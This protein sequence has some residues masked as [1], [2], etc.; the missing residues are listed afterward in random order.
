MAMCEGDTQYLRQ[1]NLF[2]LVSER[3]RTQVAAPVVTSLA[4]VTA[5]ARN[6]ATLLSGVS[7]GDVPLQAKESVSPTRGL[8]V[9]TIE[10]LDGQGGVQLTDRHGG[11]RVKLPIDSLPS[12]I[13]ANIPG[14][15][16]ER[17]KARQV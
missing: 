1:A 13:R 10:S 4:N 16:H 12:V 5:F 7:S 8:M 6:L 17:F 2:L 15:G 3:V 9:T 14:K 11:I